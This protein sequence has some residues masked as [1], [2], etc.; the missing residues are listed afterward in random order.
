MMHV[1]AHNDIRFAGRSQRQIFVVLRIDALADDFSG[2][3]CRGGHR[4]DVENSL[5]TLNRHIS[6]EFWTGKDVAIF[7][8]DFLREQERV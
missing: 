4:N 3:D 5:P 6:V 8:F 1:T 7:I 2:L